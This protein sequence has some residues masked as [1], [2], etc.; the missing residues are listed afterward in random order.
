M[1]SDGDETDIFGVRVA[2][3]RNTALISA[4]RDDIEG[5][6]IDAGSAYIFERKNGIWTQKIKLITPDGKADDRYGRGVA[7]NKD[8]AIISAMNH[9]SNGIDAGALYVYKKGSDGW[10]YSSKITAKV[11]SPKDRFGWNVGLSNR[12]ALISTPNHYGKGIHTGAVF[13]QYLNT[14]N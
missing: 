5:I 9:D 6:G 3:S 14:N 7:L 1:A 2:L 12:M 11:G 10:A 13:I 4:R 8:I